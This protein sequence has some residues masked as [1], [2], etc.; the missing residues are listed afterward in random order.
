[1]SNSVSWALDAQRE[2]VKTWDGQ[3]GSER[4][5]QMYAGLLRWDLRNLTPEQWAYLESP[6]AI[7][8]MVHLMHRVIDELNHSRMYVVERNI[9]IGLAEAQRTIPHT[10]PFGVSM[11]PCPTGFVYLEGNDLRVPH[12]HRPEGDIVRC[13]SW[14]VGPTMEDAQSDLELAIPT[15]VR[16]SIW[17]DR[18]GVLTWR[19]NLFIAEGLGWAAALDRIEY[20]GDQ[21]KVAQTSEESA[22]T[23][24]VCIR[25]LLALGAFVSE[26]IVAVDRGQAD[27]GWRKRAIRQGL[28][29]D[30]EV[31][32]VTMRELVH[33]K[34]DRYGLGGPDWSC[35]WLVHSHWR[36]QFHPSD[37]SHS[38]KLIRPYIKGDRSKPL[39]VSAPTV[40]V[41][42]R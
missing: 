9:N 32:V 29:P 11:L 37:G 17:V 35:S 26:K 20:A 8:D 10:T 30:P 28:D 38:L 27:R 14:G 3:I 31:N 15:H 41:V 6:P 39:R 12:P 24:T 18:K 5:M 16:V 42:K 7:Q 2:A 36:N 34:A 22:D 33:L 23:A 21:E 1:M 25:Y 40:R 4:A 19:Q 13:L